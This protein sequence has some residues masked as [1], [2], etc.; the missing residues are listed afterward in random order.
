[1]SRVVTHSETWTGYPTNYLSDHQYYA[2]SSQGNALAPTTNTTYANINLT[3][4]SSAVTY[5]YVT[6]DTSS[7][8]QNATITSCSGKIKCVISS[9]NSNYIKTRQ[10]QFFS[11]TN[12]KGA[13]VTVSTS[14]NVLSPTNI[15]TWSRDELD[16]ARVRFYAVRN[17]GS[18]NSSIYLRPYGADLTVNYTWDETIYSISASSNVQG[19]SVSTTSGETTSGGTN[20]ITLFG[21]SSL[22]DIQLLDNGSDVTSSLVVSGSN[23]VYT[24]TNVSADHTVTVSDITPSEVMYTKSNGSWTTMSKVYK[25]INNAWVEQTDL[26]NVFEADK[27]YVRDL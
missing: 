13:T 27:I 3:R 4:G 5:W 19:V 9:T 18:T 24:L 2:A 12:A 20:V 16:D 7:I 17:T 26:T 23:Y 14:T 6:F 1:M 15:G 22:S 21:V 10:A 25:K 11:G 8:P